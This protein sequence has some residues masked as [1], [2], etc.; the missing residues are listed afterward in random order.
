MWGRYR[1]DAVRH[2]LEHLGR[3]RVRARARAKVR[4]RVRVIVRLTFISR[5]RWRL[6]AWVGE[7]WG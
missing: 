3:V 5:A 7:G 2:R 1:L 6:S 4:V